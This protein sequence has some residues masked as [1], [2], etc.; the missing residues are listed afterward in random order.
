MGWSVRCPLPRV[1]FK[2]GW[3]SSLQCLPSFGLFEYWR[4]YF[5]LLTFIRADLGKLELWCEQT[6]DA[7][8][9]QSSEMEK[10]GGAAGLWGCGAGLHL[11]PRAWWLRSLGEACTWQAVTWPGLASKNQGVK[12]YSL[13]DGVDLCLQGRTTSQEP[14]QNFQVWCPVTSSGWRQATSRDDSLRTAPRCLPTLMNAVICHCLMVVSMKRCL[15]R[16]L[17][18]AIENQGAGF[19]KRFPGWSGIVPSTFCFVLK[20]PCCRL[21]LGFFGRGH[22]KARRGKGPFN[23]SMFSGWRMACWA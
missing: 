11:L 4:G 16:R 19:L 22:L 20:G 17:G 6:Q 8:A 15:E 18:E 10:A 21:P 1:P 13:W 2:L 14:G 12:G 5:L 3:R 7:G 23:W 9:A